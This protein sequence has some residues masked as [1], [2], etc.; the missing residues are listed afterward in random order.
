MPRLPPVVRVAMVFPFVPSLTSTLLPE[1]E[2][3]K[4]LE[5][6]KPF[7]PEFVFPPS[8]Q[9]CA[10][11]VPMLADKKRIEMNRFLVFIIFGVSG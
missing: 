6:V 9:F 10:F 2:P 11:K 4:L 5:V 7:G 8:N 1:D 3:K